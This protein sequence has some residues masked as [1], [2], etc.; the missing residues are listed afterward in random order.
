MI[1]LYNIFLIRELFL[2]GKISKDTNVFNEKEKN[3]RKI[4]KC[5][6]EVRLLSCFY[7]LTF[8]LKAPLSIFLMAK[9]DLKEKITDQNRKDIEVLKKN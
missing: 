6:V 2:I 3:K 1:G 9:L 4:N 5:A 7:E 8:D